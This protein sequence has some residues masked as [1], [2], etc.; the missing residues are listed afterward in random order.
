M[1]PYHT[2]M[3]QHERAFKACN[4]NFHA[5]FFPTKSG[6]TVEMKGFVNMVHVIFRP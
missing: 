4:G 6:K 5:P 2:A 1:C 3:A